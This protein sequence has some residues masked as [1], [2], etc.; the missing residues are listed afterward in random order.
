[1]KNITDLYSLLYYAMVTNNSKNL[2]GLPKWMFISYSFYMFHVELG[3]LCSGW[4]PCPQTDQRFILPSVLEPLK[5]WEGEERQIVHWLLIVS[6]QK[7]A[8]VTSAYISLVKEKSHGHIHMKRECICINIACDYKVKSDKYFMKNINDSH[9]PPCR[10]L[11][12][13][14]FLHHYPDTGHSTHCI[15][16]FSAYTIL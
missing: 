14:H 11:N 5:Q 7:L 4:F 2:N 8:H 6:S 10:A 16:I 13:C 1:M 15:W 9:S 12:I 3:Q